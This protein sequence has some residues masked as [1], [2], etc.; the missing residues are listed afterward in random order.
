[1]EMVEINLQGKALKTYLVISSMQKESV[2]SFYV[3]CS[4]HGFASKGFRYY[5]TSPTFP[6]SL[7]MIADLNQTKQNTTMSKKTPH[8]N[9]Q[10]KITKKPNQNEKQTTK[11]KC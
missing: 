4:L 9:P 3:S 8:K 1:M 6:T 11:K 2:V 5:P 7:M 10:N